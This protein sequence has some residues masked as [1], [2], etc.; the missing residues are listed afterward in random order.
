MRNFRERSRG[1]TRHFHIHTHTHIFPLPFLLGRFI[2]LTSRWRESLASGVW[3]GCMV[4]DVLGSSLYLLTFPMLFFFFYCPTILEAPVLRHVRIILWPL[5]WL[6]FCLRDLT[7]SA[8]GVMPVLGWSFPPP[9]CPAGVNQTPFVRV[10]ASCRSRRCCRDNKRTAS[11]L[12]GDGNGSTTMDCS[13]AQRPFEEQEKEDTNWR[14]GR[15]FPTTCCSDFFSHSHFQL[16]LPF[17][18]Q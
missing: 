5:H 8:P 4:S 1:W 10:S 17:L 15:A 18:S 9:L 16:P 11:P 14:T 7:L 2:W 3:G 6:C 12:S 13:H